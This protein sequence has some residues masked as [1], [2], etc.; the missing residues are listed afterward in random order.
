MHR[1]PHAIVPWRVE[2][3]VLLVEAEE[4]AEAATCFC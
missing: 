3:R 1:S 4:M 2:G